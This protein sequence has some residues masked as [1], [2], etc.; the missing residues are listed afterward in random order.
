MADLPIAAAV[1]PGI[2]LHKPIEVCKTRSVPCNHNEIM[3]TYSYSNRAVQ[4]MRAGAAAT[5]GHMP[6]QL[7]MRMNAGIIKSNARSEG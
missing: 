4:D 6:Q 5:P 3:D 2:D 7:I 1:L